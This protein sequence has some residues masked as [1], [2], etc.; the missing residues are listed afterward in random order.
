MDEEI[1]TSLI[2]TDEGR[3]FFVHL[4]RVPMTHAVNKFQRVQ[5]HRR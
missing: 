4:C 5:L 1:G 3:I 2:A